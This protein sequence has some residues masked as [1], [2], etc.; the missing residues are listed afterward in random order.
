MNWFRS[1][2]ASLERA[3]TQK[4]LNQSEERL[5]QLSAYLESQVQQRTGELA[6]A[7]HK[8]AINN[9]ALAE[10]NDLLVRSN[11][12]LQ[13]FAYIASHDLQEPLR[14]IPQFGDLLKTRSMDSTSE[15]FVYLERMQT[16][17]SRMST[18]IRDLLNYF[19]YFHLTGRECPLFTPD[20]CRHIVS[21]YR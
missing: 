7:N 14:K 12:N 9:Q 11:A 15:A 16:A 6:A 21:V 5:Q 10:A 17:A 13:T 1:T 4:A 2:W 19:P 8:L 20:H 18:L 3:R